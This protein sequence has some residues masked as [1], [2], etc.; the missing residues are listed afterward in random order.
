MRVYA[1]AIAVGIVDPRRLADDGLRMSGSWT[2]T[3]LWLLPLAGALVVLVLPLRD[4]TRGTLAL[5]VTIAAAVLAFAAAVDFKPSGGTQFEQ[6]HS[7]MPDFGLTYHV[8]MDG[9][10]LVLVVL[11]ATCVPC[12]LGYGLWAR[13]PEHARLRGADAAAAG[14]RRAAA[15]LPRP[16]ASSTSASS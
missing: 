10:S 5:L 1:L 15:R 13:R 3:L 2:S 6:S 12:A 14:G 11:T 4:A 8:G 7:W 9:L 16:A